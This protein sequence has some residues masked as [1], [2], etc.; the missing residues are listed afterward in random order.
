M[1]SFFHS[2][3]GSG[4]LSEWA[5]HQQTFLVLLEI[6]LHCLAVLLLRWVF[7]GMIDLDVLDDLCW[8][9]VLN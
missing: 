3:I 1:L 8:V 4:Y 5:W 2:L 6:M 9:F 7:F